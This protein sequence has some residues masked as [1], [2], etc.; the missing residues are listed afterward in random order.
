MLLQS[1]FLSNLAFAL[2]IDLA[3][4]KIVSI[5]PGSTIID[6]IIAED[7]ALTN[8]ALPEPVYTSSGNVDADAKAMLRVGWELCMSLCLCE[9]LCECLCLII[10]LGLCLWVRLWSVRCC[11]DIGRPQGRIPCKATA[12]C[13]S[14]GNVDVDAKAMLRVR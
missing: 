13:T 1:R 12:V 7:P 11:L 8:A 14:S 5:K 9:W 2:G 3:R 10:C 4:L 6:Y